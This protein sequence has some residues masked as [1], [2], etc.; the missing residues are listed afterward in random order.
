MLEQQH[1]I[2]IPS[3]WVLLA[4]FLLGIH[5][6]Q[7]A[8][9]WQ[10]VILPDNSQ[11][12][13]SE[14][15]LYTDINLTITRGLTEVLSAA[16]FSVHNGRNLNLPDCRL[17]S[18]SAITP[19]Q[20]REAAQQFDSSLNLALLYQFKAF[21]QRQNGQANW[22]FS[23][24]GRLLDLDSGMQLDAFE[25]HSRP[26]DIPKNCIVE[27]ANHWLSQQLDILSQ[28]LGAVLAD[29]LKALPRRFDYQLLLQDFSLAELQQSLEYLRQLD[30]Y[31]S[32]TLIR[33]YANNT[34][35]LQ[36]SVSREYQY[37]SELSS[38]ELGSRLAHFMDGNGMQVNIIYQQTQRQFTL[39][40]RAT[41]NVLWYASFG[42]I[43]LLLM[44][45]LWRYNK[46]KQT[47]APHINGDTLIQP[48]SINNAADD[49]GVDDNKPLQSEE[50]DESSEVIPAD[51]TNKPTKNARTLWLT[52]LLLAC[53]GVY[54]RF[55]YADLAS[56]TAAIQPI[57]SQ[58]LEANVTEQ[59]N[60]AQATPEQLA[61]FQDANDWQ[62]A[63]RI[64]TL[65][66]YQYYL[67]R[68]PAG[69]YALSASAALKVLSDDEVAWQAAV[70]EGTTEAYQA[71]LSDKPDG[72]YQQRAMQRLAL[73][74]KHSQQDQKLK[75]VLALADDYYFQQK[76]YVDA[77]YYYQQAAE[78][79]NDLAQFQLGQ[80]YSQ[81]QGTTKNERIAHQW[82]Q[83]AA[84]QGHAQA[85][86]KLAYGYSKG[87]GV[88]QDH[89]QAIYWYQQAAQQ[90][91]LIAQYNLAYI[92]TQGQVT[93]RDYVKA[94]YWYQQAAAQGDAD[95]QNNLA[96]LYEN[97]QGVAQDLSKAKSLYRQAAAQGH[98]V[99]KI[100]LS[101]IT[102]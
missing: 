64:N 83:Q 1:Y 47:F 28:E 30:S 27:C 76:N 57:T 80:I 7:A 14:V 66:S 78:L 59:T 75:D 2:K 69:R 29:K 62:Q 81:G 84:Q 10:V 20:I 96:K 19:Q 99:A 79:G 5:S 51:N 23:L 17:T 33:E 39:Q 54:W 101:L 36:H 43:A 74:F 87:V 98:Q 22:H 35:W 15:S 37:S 24:A 90:G 32:D 67:N 95:A 18:C 94:A 88:G 72:L 61:A 56:P 44:A 85:Q 77:L 58:Q 52:L 3:V 9:R 42:V 6:A 38:A 11:T 71:Y 86:F 55:Y 34:Q 25:S 41:S 73:I 31:V 4:L 50:S 45:V 26:N 91:V 70:R 16:D 100:N 8:E 63:S 53:A 49:L 13:P 21:K 97:G 12:I 65:Q 89:Q 68:W 48:N 92:Y 40:R 82:Y 46:R 93:E 102:Q 60:T